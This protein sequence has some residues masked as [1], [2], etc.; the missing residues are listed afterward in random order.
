MESFLRDEDVH[1]L[2]FHTVSK[3]AKHTIPYAYD[4]DGLVIELKDLTAVK[5]PIHYL[6][7]GK[8]AGQNLQNYWHSLKKYLPLNVCNNAEVSAFNKT[9]G[10]TLAFMDGSYLLNICLITVEKQHPH[11]VFHTE[12]AARANAAHVINQVFHVF[13]SNF[14]ALTP[15]DLMRPTVFKTNMNELGRMN[16]VGDDQMFILGLLMQAIRQVD[17][18]LTQ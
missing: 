11:P 3:D 15:E 2:L 5:A 18:D 13:A 9:F 1:V 10:H 12:V 7:V 16:I 6:M 8:V 4:I 17:Q 14:K